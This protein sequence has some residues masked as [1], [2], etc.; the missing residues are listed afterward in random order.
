GKPSSFIAFASAGFVGSLP[1]KNTWISMDIRR[2]RSTQPMRLP[3][4]MFLFCSKRV[5]RQS[6]PPTQASPKPPHQ[7]LD[8][9]H[10]SLGHLAQ[11]LRWREPRRAVRLR[12]FGSLAGSRRPLHLE[13]V[14]PKIPQIEIAFGRPRGDHLAAGLLE[15]AQLERV[16]WW[17][18]AGLLL[19]LAA[20]CA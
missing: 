10:L 15:V 13:H 16:G 20:R 11:P 3:G 5:K 2:P 7:R 17:Q 4:A 18:A 19:E 12:K 1:R 14:A 8:N 9:R 6:L